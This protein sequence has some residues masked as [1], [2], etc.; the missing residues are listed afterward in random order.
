ME[1]SS[2]AVVELIEKG[3]CRVCLRLTDSGCGV[4]SR[5][6]WSP[7]NDIQGIVDLKF[8]ARLRRERVS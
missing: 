8:S 7:R 6:I 2:L 3:E 5:Y 1:W 4:V